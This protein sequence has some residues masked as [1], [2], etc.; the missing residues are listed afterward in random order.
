MAL[1]GWFLAVDYYEAF[2]V[3]CDELVQGLSVSTGDTRAMARIRGTSEDYVGT[4]ACG[5]LSHDSF[6]E[7]DECSAKYGA[8]CCPIHISTLDHASIRNIVIYTVPS[9]AWR[10]IT[11]IEIRLHLE[12]KVT[13]QYSAPC[14]PASAPSYHREQIIP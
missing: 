14:A 2:K 5:Y 13:H 11:S 10:I 12:L 8:R 7:C 6:V 9:I 3:N 4:I 1:L